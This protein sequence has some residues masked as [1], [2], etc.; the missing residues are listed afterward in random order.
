MEG[1]GGVDGK[2]ERRERRRERRE[3]M[4]EKMVRR[5]TY[6]ISYP[7]FA[8]AARMMAFMTSSRCSVRNMCWL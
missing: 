3:G 7:M 2:K 1:E 4:K 6:S 5:R 8:R